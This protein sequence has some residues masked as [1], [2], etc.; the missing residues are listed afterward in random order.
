MKLVGAEDIIIERA[1]C[2]GR[3]KLDQPVATLH[4]GQST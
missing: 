1:H 2:S 4:Q 3:S